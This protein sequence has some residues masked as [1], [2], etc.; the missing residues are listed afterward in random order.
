MHFKLTSTLNTASGLSSMK[1]IM[2]TLPCLSHLWVHLRNK[3][4]PCKEPH[5]QSKCTSYGTFCQE[6]NMLC[7][8]R[9]AFSAVHCYRETNTS[10]HGTPETSKT[11]MAWKQQSFPPEVKFKT[12]PSIRKIMT[13]IFH[14]QR[15]AFC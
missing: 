10:Y 2:L 4:V 15:C 1:Y 12:V 8:I 3:Y 9:T 6:F 11:S 5:K 14:P 13:T 7:S